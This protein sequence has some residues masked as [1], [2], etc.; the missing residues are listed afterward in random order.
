[1]ICP[2]CKTKNPDDT[3]YCHQCGYQLYALKAVNVKICPNCGKMNPLDQ[4]ECLNCHT[5][6]DTTPIQE[7]GKKGNTVNSADHISPIAK[8]I[9][10]LIIVVFGVIIIIGVY[11]SNN[12]ISTI[13]RPLTITRHYHKQHS[14]TKKFYI[15]MVFQ[16]PVQR[17]HQME[18][19]QGVRYK[20]YI[21][22]NHVSVQQVKTKYHAV[23]ASRMQIKMTS[24][25]ARQLLSSTIPKSLNTSHNIKIQYT[26]QSNH[27]Y[28]VT[29]DRKHQSL[30][31]HGPD[32][33]DYISLG[34]AE[35]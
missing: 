9:L 18:I 30:I 21:Q 26:W 23:P 6:L 22:T 10:T 11:H 27:W 12:Y 34:E 33:T 28:N 14:V 4:T 5:P 17:N 20:N 25:A 3:Q 13:I 31:V 16:K 15:A 1:M 7:S 19:F 35:Q 29:T 24:S 2:R 32:F 8:L